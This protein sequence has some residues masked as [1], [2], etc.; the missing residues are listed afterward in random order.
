M[1][2]QKPSFEVIHSLLKD[3]MA[4]QISSSRPFYYHTDD[5]KINKAFTNI[6]ARTGKARPTTMP[7]NGPPEAEKTIWLQELSTSEVQGCGHL[8]LMISMPQTYGLPDATVPRELIKALYQEFWAAADK[9]KFQIVTKLGPLVGKA[10][11][12]VSNAGP[13]CKGSSPAI[14]PNTFGSSVFV[15]TPNAAKAF[16]KIVLTEFFA[17]KNEA[18]SKNKDAFASAVD[19]LLDKQLGATLVNLSPANAINLIAVNVATVAGP[20]VENG[21]DNDKPPVNSSGAAGRMTQH[22]IISCVFAVSFLLALLRL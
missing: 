22:G 2:A 8:R 5:S 20:P 3:F 18:I 15:Y 19:A 6:A 12:I 1:T 13:V 17:K 21:K 14:E 10:I 4:E 16:R 9:S 7:V 11:A